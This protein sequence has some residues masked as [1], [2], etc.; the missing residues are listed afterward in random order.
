MTPNR[1]IVLSG[2]G[3]KDLEEYQKRH[4]TQEELDYVRQADEYLES[5]PPE[6]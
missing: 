2:K 5:H 6:E 3:S 1:P 4:V